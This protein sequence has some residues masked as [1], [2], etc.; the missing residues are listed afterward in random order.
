MP[1]RIENR[2][3][4]DSEWAFLAPKEVAEKLKEKGYHENSTGNFVPES[5]AYEYA[6][7]RSL[8][9]SEQDV[10]DFKEMLVEWFYSGGDWR[11]EE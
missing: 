11:K 7:E 9:G 3:V 6:L 5:K 8:H 10:K 4:V 1:E 2:M